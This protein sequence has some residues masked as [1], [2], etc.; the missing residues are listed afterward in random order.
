LDVEG[1]DA[2]R[3]KTFRPD[4]RIRPPPRRSPQAKCFLA[5]RS[6]GPLAIIFA[7]QNARAAFRSPREYLTGEL[8]IKNNCMLKLG[9]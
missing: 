5:Q 4:R 3:E 2:G 9:M 7:Q 1:F 8:G 6:P